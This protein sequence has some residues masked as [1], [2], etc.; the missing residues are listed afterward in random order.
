MTYLLIELQKYNLWNT[1]VY[2][3]IHLQKHFIPCCIRC[4][5]GF[6]G[7]FERTPHIY[8]ISDTPHYLCKCHSRWVQI[9]SA[10]S[11][12]LSHSGCLCRWMEPAYGKG[13]SC[14]ESTQNGI[15]L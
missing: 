7:S 2:F 4:C 13:N 1:Y 11:S 10:N 3:F 12:R 5:T 15:A 8:D 9:V 6:R 14:V